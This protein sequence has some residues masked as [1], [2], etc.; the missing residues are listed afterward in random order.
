M[1][2]FVIIVWVLAAFKWSN[3]KNWRLY[4][5]TILFYIVGNFIYSFLTYNYPL[6]ELVSVSGKTTF[7]TMQAILIAWP[8]SMLLYLSLFPKTKDW[9][10]RIGY[11]LGWSLFYW[12]NELVLSWFGYYR[13][14]NGWNVWW[15]LGF[16]VVMFPLLKIHYEFPPFAWIL[17]IIIGVSVIWFFHIPISS[18]K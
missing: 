16:N 1:R 17:A 7:P 6:W 3:W 18:M 11:V 14:S 13:Y 9:G 8:S 4:Y 2:L 12:L 15:S 5:P 10:P